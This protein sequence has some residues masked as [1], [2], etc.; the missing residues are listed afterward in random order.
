MNGGFSELAAGVFRFAPYLL[1]Y[2]QAVPGL[3]CWSMMFSIGLCLGLRYRIVSNMHQLDEGRVAMWIKASSMAV[4]SMLMTLCLICIKCNTA[5]G[6]ALRSN[7][8]C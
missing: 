3:F 8:S 2:V 7:A 4:V 1:S 6:M 5:V